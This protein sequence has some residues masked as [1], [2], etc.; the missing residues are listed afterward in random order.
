MGALV[1]A[2]I[3]RISK[4][5]TLRQYATGVLLIPTGVSLVWFSFRRFGYL[6]RAFGNAGGKIID[7]V[8]ASEA[9]GFFAL[10]DTLPGAGVL[11][12][13]AMFSVAVFFITS[14][15]S[16]TYVNG[17]LTSGGA[18]NPP[19]PLRITWGIFQLGIAAILLFT[20]GNAALKSLQT[21]LLSVASPLC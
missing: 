13:V 6:C 14:S 11:T 2:F 3:A 8:S 4:G 1:G 21:A 17:M 10:M 7:A 9:S 16:G 19:L 5:R 18:A 12:A 15:D 20:G